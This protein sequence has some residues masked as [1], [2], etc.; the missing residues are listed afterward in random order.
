MFFGDKAPRFARTLHP[1]EQLDANAV[2]LGRMPQGAFL[3]A[4]LFERDGSRM[5]AI[6]TRFAQGQQIGLLITASLAAK[7]DVMYF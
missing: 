4:L 3:R 5:Q 6:M 7:N 1:L 2:H